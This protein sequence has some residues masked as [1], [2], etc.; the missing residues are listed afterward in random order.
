MQIYYLKQELGRNAKWR[1]L[2]VGFKE[3][4]ALELTLLP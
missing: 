4:Q 2:M 3:F 1:V